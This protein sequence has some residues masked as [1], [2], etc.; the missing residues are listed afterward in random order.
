V[1]IVN[2]LVKMFGDGLSG[3]WRIPGIWGKRVDVT[4]ENTTLYAGDRDMFVFLADE[5]NRIEYAG[6]DSLARG[7]FTWNSEVGACTYGLKGFLFREACQNRIVWDVEG[8]EELRIRH[9]KCAPAKFLEE[10]TPAILALSQASDGNIRQAIENAK[11]QR[12][13][14]DVNKFLAERFGPRVAV[15]MAA[16]FE[17]DEGRPPETG[18]DV[19]NA[20]TAYARQI[21]FQPER[22]DL[23][24]QAGRLLKAF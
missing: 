11:A 17:S 16:A 22:V 13:D 7:F 10:A 18:W 24:T 15:K 2:A 5:I 21:P 14:N 12:L 1:D 20:V 4:K 19:V 3:D 6:R 9:S 23:E 8:I